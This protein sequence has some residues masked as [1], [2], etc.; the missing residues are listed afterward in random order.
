MPPERRTAL[1]P[2][3]ARHGR[4]APGFS[5]IEILLVLAVMAL[6]GALLLPGVNSL[7]RSISEVEPDAIFRD[8]I[9]A[10][11][12]QALGSNQTVVLRY[13][14]E[15]R[16][17][18]WGDDTHRQQQE[19]PPGT[20]LQLLQPTTGGSVLLGGVLVETQEVA[21]VR[22]YPD[23]TCDRFRAQISRGRARSQVIAIDPW[24]CAPLP[25]AAV[26]P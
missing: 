11:R 9:T 22:F 24:T 20:A 3:L 17:L 25:E 19:L 8:V 26:S 14:R 6:L 15:G 7:L 4:F 23:G 16:M 2:R 13:E 1:P 10:A 18:R 5:L 21:M 12:E